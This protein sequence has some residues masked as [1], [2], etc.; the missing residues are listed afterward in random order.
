MGLVGV[1]GRVLETAGWAW[2]L[3]TVLFL[4]GSCSHGR[5]R[6]RPGILR[7]LVLFW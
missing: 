3:V 2:L 4:I 6:R 1:F 7:C 5:R